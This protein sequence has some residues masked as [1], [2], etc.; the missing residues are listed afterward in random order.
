M[1]QVLVRSSTLADETR[2]HIQHLYLSLYLC[3][4]LCLCLFLY[5]DRAQQHNGDPSGTPRDE[6]RR[7]T[8][9][10]AG[11]I[12]LHLEGGMGI[13]APRQPESS[14]HFNMWLRRSF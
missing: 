12:I 11:R 2:K 8:Q 13:M 3:L 4:F 1:T 5:T 10:S 14:E 6:T 7:G 9:S